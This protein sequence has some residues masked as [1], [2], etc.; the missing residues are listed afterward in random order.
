[1][2]KQYTTLIKTIGF[3]VI[4]TFVAVSANVTAEPPGGQP[5]AF[6]KPE[7]V[8]AQQDMNSRVKARRNPYGY[9]FYRHGRGHRHGPARGYY[10]SIILSAQSL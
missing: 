3:C 1:M 5:L 8:G 9:Q 10:Y 6:G 4:M 2:T 7:V